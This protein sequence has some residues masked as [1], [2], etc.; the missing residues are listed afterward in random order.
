MI[1][2]KTTEQNNEGMSEKEKA[3]LTFQDIMNR[4]AWSEK[5]STIAVNGKAKCDTGELDKRGV[6]EQGNDN[7]AV[8]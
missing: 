5:R 7:T 2:Y 1:Y 4:Q 6:R 8:G 3:G